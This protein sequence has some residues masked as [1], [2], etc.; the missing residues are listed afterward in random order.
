MA[1]SAVFL[2]AH[3]ISYPINF[4]SG[5]AS[6]NLLMSAKGYFDLYDKSINAMSQI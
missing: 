5:I 1:F 2:N 4:E 3:P 6:C